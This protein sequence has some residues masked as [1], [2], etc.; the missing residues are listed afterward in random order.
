MTPGERGRIRREN[1]AYLVRLLL[2]FAFGFALSWL[3]WT[4][5]GHCADAAVSVRT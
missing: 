2:W 3:V 4:Y 5:T 1:R